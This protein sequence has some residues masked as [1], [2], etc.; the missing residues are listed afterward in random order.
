MHKPKRNRPKNPKKKMRKEAAPSSTIKKTAQQKNFN[1]PLNKGRGGLSRATA[2]FVLGL[3]DFGVKHCKVVAACVVEHSRPLEVVAFREDAHVGVC[4]E[5]F[6]H[7][8]GVVSRGDLVDDFA[9]DVGD[10]LLD[11][12]SADFFGG[13][14]REVCFLELVEASPAESAACDDGLQQLQ[15]GHVDD[16]LA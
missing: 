8:Q 5:D 3:V 16:E 6:S 9:F 13:Q 2:N 1:L 15:R 11:G 14:R 7:K 10:A 4:F 12:G